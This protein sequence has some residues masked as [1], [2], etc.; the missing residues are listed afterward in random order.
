MIERL[1]VGWQVMTC[2]RDNDK[3]WKAIDVMAIALV[4][5]AASRERQSLRG[6]PLSLGARL[7]RA[8]PH[9]ARRRLEAWFWASNFQLVTP[10]VNELE[11]WLQEGRKVPNVIESALQLV[12]SNAFREQFVAARTGRAGTRIDWRYLMLEARLCW[13][14]SAPQTHEISLQARPSPFAGMSPSM[15]EIIRMSACRSIISCP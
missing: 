13:A 2:I 1:L 11:I 4:R 14:A 10:D 15:T 8:L 9:P 7:D 6:A 12:R 3:G 5:A